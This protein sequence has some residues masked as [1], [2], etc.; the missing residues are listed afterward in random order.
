M[1]VRENHRGRIVCQRLFD[2]FA[3]MH[4]RTIDGA[5]EQL[6]EGDQSMPI[7]EVQAAE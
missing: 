6:F 1:V 2:Y 3:G 5:A 7:V 4:A